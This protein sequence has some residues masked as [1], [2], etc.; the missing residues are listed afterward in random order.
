MF[1]TASSLSFG[2]VG[3]LRWLLWLHGPFFLSSI[4]YLRCASW[5]PWSV[6]WL[7]LAPGLDTDLGVAAESS[8]LFGIVLTN[9]RYNTG[10]FYIETSHERLMEST[11]QTVS[12]MFLSIFGVLGFWTSFLFVSSLLFSKY[13]GK[14]VF[15]Y[16]EKSIANHEINGENVIF[17]C[18]NVIKIAA[19]FLRRKAKK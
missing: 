18:G 11:F 5:S 15:F 13:N 2:M 17:N 7:C 14:N 19:R 4:V 6:S 12:S 9:K 16:G 1:W 3:R 8:S 10:S